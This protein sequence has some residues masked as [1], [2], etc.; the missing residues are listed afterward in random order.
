[1]L[2][3]AAFAFFLNDVAYSFQLSTTVSRFYTS[4]TTISGRAVSTY[5]ISEKLAKLAN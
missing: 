4:F 1:M 3:F 2:V 5:K